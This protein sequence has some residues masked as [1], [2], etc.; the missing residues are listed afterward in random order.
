MKRSKKYNEVS[1]KVLE[2]MTYSVD[3]ALKLAKETSYSKFTG[4]IDVSIN[5]NVPD[6]FKKD[7]FRG[8]ITLPHQ[9]TSA[10][11]VAVI[12]MGQDEADAKAAGADE[13]GGDELIKKIEGGYLDFDILIS[14]PPMMAKMAKLG[15]V[16][17]P[18]GLMP[19]PRNETV[20]TEV[21]RVITNYKKGKMDFKLDAQGGIKAKFGKVDMDEVA[22]KEN[23]LSFVKSAY[24]ET[25][26][27]GPNRIRSVYVCATMGPSIKIDKNDFLKVV[28]A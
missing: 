24:S 19:N 6:K 3:E 26:K 20:T 12:A 28:E 7:P 27:L 25:K 10:V 18:K 22:L 1:K 8:S 15:K 11:R 9:I 5:F 13:V 2:G 23:F 21:A 16:L 4:G 17:G 14:T